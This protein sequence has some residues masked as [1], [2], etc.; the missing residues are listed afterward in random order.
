MKTFASVVLSLLIA[1]AAAAQPKQLDADVARALQQFRVPGASICIVK[2]GQ[3]VLAKGFGVRKLGDPA[4]VDADTLFQVASNTKAFTTAALA[5]LVDEKKLAWDDKVT[6]HLPSF[7]MYDPYAS[8]E[9]TVRDLVTHRAGLGLGAGDLMIYPGTDY[10]RDEI[11]AH[12]RFI[13]PATSF[14]SAYAYNNIMFVVA[15]KVIEAVSGRRYEDFVRERILTPLG[16]TKTVLS[17][18]EL[19]ASANRETPHAP[20]GDRIVPIRYDTWNNAAPAGGMATSANDIAKWMLARLA[21]GEY[22]PSKRLFSAKQAYE[23]WQAQTLIRIPEPKGALAPLSPNFAAYAMGWRLRDYRG[24]KVVGHSG[25]LTGTVSLI[26][27]IPD[28]HLGI[29]VFTNQQAT[30]FTNAI[31]WLIADSYLGA[32]RTDWIETYVKSD[33][34][35]EKRYTDEKQKHDAARI[36]DAAPLPAAKYAGRYTDPWYGDVTIAEEN[37]KLVMRFSHT[38]ELVGDLEPWQHD[39]FIAR[40]RDRFLDADAFVTFTLTPDGEVKSAVMEPISS[41]TDFSFDFQDLALAKVR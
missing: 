2:D 15:G 33:A 18:P 39:T 22:A 25:G 37:G 41:R 4:P 31:T 29:A 17:T 19:E 40:W 30:E 11:V 34:E 14:R 7:A 21:D 13:K 20:E 8:Q 3:V 24:H 9:V 38:P 36:K 6:K 26:T 12:V 32:P 35:S 16:M 27:L 1:A 5:I 28:Q 23:M 10:T